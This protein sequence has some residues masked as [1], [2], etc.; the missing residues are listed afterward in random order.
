MLSL[1]ITYP[2]D[3]VVASGECSVYPLDVLSNTVEEDPDEEVVIN[4]IRQFTC[5]ERNNNNKK[6]RVREVIK[7]DH[8]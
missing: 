2:F 7:S 5:Y 6:K 8:G 1:T 3:S 4:R